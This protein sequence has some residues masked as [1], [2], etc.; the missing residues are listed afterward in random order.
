MSNVY[1]AVA[2]AAQDEKYNHVI[3]VYIFSIV[4]MVDI[5]SFKEVW[6][7]CKTVNY[8]H[9]SK[10][11]DENPRE[12]KIQENPRKL[13]KISA[14]ITNRSEANLDQLSNGKLQFSILLCK[15]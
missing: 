7:G 8:R 3:K 9:D 14:N 13:K 10:H 1:I 2:E 5:V 12:F 15:H 4:Y 6:I 11:I